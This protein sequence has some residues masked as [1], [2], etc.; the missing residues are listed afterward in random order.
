[1]AQALFQGYLP[2]IS[3]EGDESHVYDII[4]FGKNLGGRD[5]VLTKDGQEKNTLCTDLKHTSKVTVGN[6]TKDV[7]R[8]FTTYTIYYSP[9]H[10]Y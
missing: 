2:L 9:I 10:V 3:S 8:Q 5:F 7:S 4:I 6:T 1:M